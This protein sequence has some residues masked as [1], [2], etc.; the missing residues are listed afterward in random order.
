MADRIARHRSERGDE[1]VTVEAPFELVETL[2]SLADA[3]VVVVDCLTLWLSNLLLRDEG[4]ER[5]LA[6]V[7]ALAALLARRLRHTVLVTNEVGM[8]VV[9]PSALGRRFRDLAGIAHQRLARSADEIYFGML[10][11]MLRLRPAPVALVL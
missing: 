10:G 4:E 6:R 11:A 5:I 7:D 1:F 2:E 9:P 8:S 3:D